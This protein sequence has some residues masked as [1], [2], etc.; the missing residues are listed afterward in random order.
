[1]A[2]AMPCFPHKDT[3]IL[4]HLPSR[5]QKQGGGGGGVTHLLA[6]IF[7]R[8]AWVTATAPMQLT[9]SWL[10]LHHETTQQH[11]AESVAQTAERSAICKSH[12]SVD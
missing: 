6:T 1:M 8:K 9:L 11:A 2:R 10:F 7:G 4:K 5:L 3:M 12:Q